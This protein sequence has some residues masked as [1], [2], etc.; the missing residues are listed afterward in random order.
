MFA[1]KARSADSP[2]D[3]K[4]RTDLSASGAGNLDLAMFLVSSCSPEQEITTVAQ[5]GFLVVNDAVTFAV[6]AGPFRS[7]HTKRTQAG[8]LRDKPLHLSTTSTWQLRCPIITDVT[9][10]GRLQIRSVSV[11]ST[12]LTKNF[13][14]VSGCVRS[15]VLP[16]VEGRSMRPSPA[17]SLERGA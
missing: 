12:D 14:M 15:H 2:T 5:P 3:E 6:G 16:P 8:R 11:L 17:S 4:R 10:I 9:D 7:A 13:S 1:S